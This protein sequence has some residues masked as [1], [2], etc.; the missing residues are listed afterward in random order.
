[1]IYEVLILILP[2]ITSPYIARVIGADG[3]GVFSF[4]YTVAFYFVLF[5]MLGIKNHGNRAIARVRDD[6]NELNHTFSDIAVLHIAVSLVCTMCYV[7]YI[8]CL[9]GDDRLYAFI[10][11]FYVLSAV[12]DISWFYF[13]IEKFKLTVTRN[14]IVKLLTVLSVFI[15]VKTKNDLWIYCLIMSLGNLVSQVALWVPLRKFVRFVKPNFSNMLRHLKPLFILFLPAIAVSLYKHMDK[16][17][18][19]TLS[20][21]VQLGFYENADKM[22]G[23]PLTVIVSFGTVMLPKMSNLVKKS[24][25]GAQTRRL[26]EDSMKYVMCIAFALAFG[27]G[28]VSTVFAPVFWGED[29]SASGAIIMGLSTTIPFISFADVIRTQF[30]IPREKDKEY[31]ISVISGAVLNLIINYLLIPPL[32]ALGAMIGTISAEVTVCTIQAFVVR[33]ALPLKRYFKNM[34]FF[35][36]LGVIMAA[37]VYALGMIMGNSVLTLILQVFLGVA[38]YGAGAVVYF[39]KTK[40][41]MIIGIYE[42]KIKKL[43]KRKA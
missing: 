5:S 20:N 17:M 21:K 41:T 10:M 7:G 3:L 36:V 14:T 42:N 31:L 29:F 1:M 15:F 39:F 26:M 38:I 34:L 9:Q 19:G 12:F 37:A 24:S 18:I 43:F 4:S 11:F 16:I 8:F 6:Q 28:S 2:L 32:G 27:L 40:D 22:V 33:K 30:L 35:L 13:G 25:S 23:I